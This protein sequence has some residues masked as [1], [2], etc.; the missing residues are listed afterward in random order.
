MLCSDILGFVL[1]AFIIL[2][3]LMIALKVPLYLSLSLSAGLTLVIH[4]IF[5]KLL[6]V[7]LPVGL[8]IEGFDL[9]KF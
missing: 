8:L 3:G 6:G 7:P 2:T 4:L 1:T 5:Y 9:W